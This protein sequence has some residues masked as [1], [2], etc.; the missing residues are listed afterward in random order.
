MAKTAIIGFGTVGSGI[1]EILKKN[2][3]KEKA[4]EDIDLKRILDIRDFGDHEASELFTKDFD[5]LCGDAEIDVVAETMGG[6]HPAYEYTK[7]LLAAGKSVVTS[8]KELVATYGPELLKIASENNVNY[9]FE[10][11]VGGGIPII[12]PMTSCLLAN[13]IEKIAGI[14][15]GTTNYILTEM[16]EK[17]KSFEA[18][19]ADAQKLGYAERNPA[20][21]VEGYDA[22]R[23][24][25]I[26]ASLAWGRFVP[27]DSVKTEGITAISEEDVKGAESLG[28]VIKLIGYAEKA[29]DKINIMVRP[30]LVDKKMMLAGVSGVF[31]AVEVKGDF[32]GE[33]MFYGR[34]AGKE[35]TA[36]AVTAD[37]ID[38]VK[39][40]DSKK[41]NIYWSTEDNDFVLKPGAD[42]A[43][44]FIRTEGGCTEIEAAEY[45]ADKNAF[46]TPKMTAEQLSKL[47][48]N[49]KNIKS[50]IRVLE[51]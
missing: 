3:F 50:V 8:N 38:C 37:I 15:N 33:A 26:L 46:I 32:L 25:A 43:S 14:L 18:A 21:D 24:I 2:S 36:S 28:R 23:K 27:Y 19:L 45:T 9:M 1:Y 6:L 12:R 17:G 7:R 4:G 34:G 49:K 13:N 29:G 30:M 39:H 44:Y 51:V 42:E 16:F 22:C 40:K 47:V 20:A 5:V 10:A 31:N 35:A 48:E 41:H 11:S